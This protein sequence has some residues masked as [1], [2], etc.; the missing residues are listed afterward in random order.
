MN[1]KSE[2]IAFIPNNAQEWLD[3]VR[4]DRNLFYN[5]PDIQR[6]FKEDAT[7]A[8]DIDVYKRQALKSDKTGLKLY[9]FLLKKYPIVND[10]CN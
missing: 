3:R 4:L 1:L 10:I 6:N 7:L 5:L 9:N 8:R 2:S